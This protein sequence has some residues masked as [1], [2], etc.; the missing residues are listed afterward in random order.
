VYDD[1]GAL[2]KI[3]VVN[4]QS[5]GFANPA[6]KVEQK[7]NQ[8]FVTQI[9]GGFLE[10]GHLAKFQVSLTRLVASRVALRSGHKTA[11]SVKRAQVL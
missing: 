1:N 4:L 5:Q 2:H 7:A 10:P 8:N 6:S 9:G 11:P 3:Y